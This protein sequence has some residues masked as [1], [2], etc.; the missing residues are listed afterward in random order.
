MTSGR[1]T[2]SDPPRLESYEAERAAYRVEVPDRFNAVLDI[3]ERWASEAPGDIALLSLDG[4]G[5]VV[6]EQTV[7][8]LALESRRAARALL[9]LGIGKG[10]PVF[11]M[12]P[13][14]RPGTPPSWGRSASARS[15]CRAPTSSPRGTSP[16]A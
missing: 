12:L 5:G 2:R 4:Q 9:E 13:R 1:P 7:G 10:D 15:R 6:A 14:S 8:D 11:V 16:T 3:I